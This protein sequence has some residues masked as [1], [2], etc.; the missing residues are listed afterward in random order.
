VRYRR[1]KAAGVLS[2]V[3]GR[4]WCRWRGFFAVRATFESRIA[5]PEGMLTVAMRRMGRRSERWVPS[6]SDRVMEGGGFMES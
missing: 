2:R 6:R 3:G 4:D 5:L 1:V